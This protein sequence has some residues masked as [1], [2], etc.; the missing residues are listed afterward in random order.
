M[1]VYA[2]E[3]FNLFHYSYPDYSSVDVELPG[4]D[5]KDVKVTYDNGQIYLNDKQ[6]AYGFNSN[7]FDFSGAKAE[8]K[9]GLLKITIPRKKPNRTEIPIITS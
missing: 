7:F 8:L 1:K 2:N 6:I 9:H 4:V 3:F 5:P